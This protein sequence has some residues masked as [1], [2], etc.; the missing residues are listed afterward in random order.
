M[1]IKYLNIKSQST[2]LVLQH[3]QKCESSVEV[4]SSKHMNLEAFIIK[5][6]RWTLHFSRKVGNKYQPK[7]YKKLEG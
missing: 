3:K 6:K 7:L 5:L 4:A 2:I 1:K